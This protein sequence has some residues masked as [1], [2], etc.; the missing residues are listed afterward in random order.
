METMETTDTADTAIRNVIEDPIY[1]L[2]P[3]CEK[4][5]SRDPAAVTP[6]NTIY[7]AY[8][9]FCAAQGMINVPKQTLSK[10]IFRLNPCART[11]RRGKVP[12]S[13]S[14]AWIWVGVKINC[15]GCTGC[16]E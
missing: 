6:K 16:E 13:Q 11:A 15:P 10:A 1:G 12:N 7:E 8:L 4:C 14:R 9:K 5:L 3:F 2:R